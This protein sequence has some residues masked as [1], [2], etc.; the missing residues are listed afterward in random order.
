MQQLCIAADSVGLVM[1]HHGL[2]EPQRHCIPQPL[3]LGSVMG[4]AVES[5]AQRASNACTRVAGMLLE[6]FCEDEPAFTISSWLR[7]DASATVSSASA[8]A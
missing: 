6:R 7:G 3:S 1:L 4:N 8:A 5:P 2:Y